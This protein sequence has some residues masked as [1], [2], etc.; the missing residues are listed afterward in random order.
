[1]TSRKSQNHGQ[2]DTWLNRLGWQKRRIM[3]RWVKGFFQFKRSQ[4]IRVGTVDIGSED[5][6][7]ESPP[8]EE[9]GLQPTPDPWASLN[10]REA[11][12]GHALCPLPSLHCAQHWPRE[13]GPGSRLPQRDRGPEG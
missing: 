4:S 1:M 7:P 13:A 8:E 2:M 11:H 9:G 6:G 5:V 10:L 12:L 3:H